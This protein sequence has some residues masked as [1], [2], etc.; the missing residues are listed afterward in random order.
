MKFGSLVVFLLFFG[1]ALI[2][3]IQKRNWVEA[4]VFAALG[5]LSLWADRRNR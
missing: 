1:V 2:G 4:I 3:A 5:V